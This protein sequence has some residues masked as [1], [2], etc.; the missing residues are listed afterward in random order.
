MALQYFD[1]YGHPIEIME[2]G[3]LCENPDYK[4]IKQ[5]TVGK[6]FVSTVWLGLNMSWHKEMPKL[7]FETMIFS[8]EKCNHEYHNDNDDPALEYMQ[9]YET[10]EDA[11]MGHEYAIKI[12][13]GEI[14]INDGI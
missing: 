8:D 4:I 13:S 3:R 7:I 10:L 1:K 9:R 2:W 12:A 6:Y 11:I 14:S 5:Q